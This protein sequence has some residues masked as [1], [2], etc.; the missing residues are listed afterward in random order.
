MQVALHGNPTFNP[1][2]IVE[3]VNLMDE[4]DFQNLSN[5]SGWGYVE[6][7]MPMTK[8]YIIDKCLKEGLDLY[9]FIFRETAISANLNKDVEFINK[10]GPSNNKLQSKVGVTQD[11][12]KI[13]SASLQQ[14]LEQLSRNLGSDIQAQMRGCFLNLLEN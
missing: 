6:K 8:D 5:V 11:S 12:N 1:K 14:Y 2:I 13:Q 10:Y 4:I 9:S 3:K 7:H